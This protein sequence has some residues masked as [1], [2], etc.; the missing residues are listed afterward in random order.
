MYI[1]GMIKMPDEIYQKIENLYEMLVDYIE[2]DYKDVD[3]KD[4]ELVRKVFV[5]KTK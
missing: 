3:G 1:S 2:R 5:N 4:I